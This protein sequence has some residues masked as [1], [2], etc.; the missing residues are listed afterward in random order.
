MI[1]LSTK[2]WKMAV[3]KDGNFADMDGSVIQRV[4]GVDSWGGFYNW[5]YDH[6]C[7]RPNANGILTMLLAGSWT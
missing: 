6:Y 3:L 1:F 7:Y 4:A 2:T 5:Y